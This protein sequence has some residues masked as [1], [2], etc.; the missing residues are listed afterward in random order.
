MKYCTEIK[1]SL[2][3]TNRTR[4]LKECQ[5][6]YTTFYKIYTCNNLHSILLLIGVKKKIECEKKLNIGSLKSK[7]LNGIIGT[8]IQS[9]LL[10]VKH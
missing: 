8:S 3:L 2:I 5:S 1:S 9:Y 10:I 7:I 6:Q 4:V